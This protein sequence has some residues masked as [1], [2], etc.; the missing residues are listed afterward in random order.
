MNF[1]ESAQLTTEPHMSNSI[2]QKLTTSFRSDLP[3]MLR[4]K[5]D[6][7]RTEEAGLTRAYQ[8]LA[9]AAADGSKSQADADKAHAALM[10]HHAT[11]S[12]TEAALAAAERRDEAQKRDAA[13]EGAE[14]AWDKCIAAS[15]A[16]E[17]IAAAYAAAIAEAGKRYAE[18]LAAGEKVL[19]SVPV[20]TPADDQYGF[21]PDLERLTL[22]EYVLHKLPGSRGQNPWGSTVTSFV[23]RFAEHTKSI[24]QARDKALRALTGSS[25]ED[26]A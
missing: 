12:R 15:R 26:A 2:I 4:K 5:L 3:D 21:H 23:P 17:P 7:L 24:E 19:L 18:L 6:V 9:M 13:Y 1:P 25:A 14:A 8:D 16:R 10:A 20:G 11:V 22:T